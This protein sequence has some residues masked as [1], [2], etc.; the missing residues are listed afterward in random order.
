MSIEEEKKERVLEREMEGW[1]LSVMHS[2]TF[3]P[4]GTSSVKGIWSL[5]WLQRAPPS[6]AAVTHTVLPA[7]DL[8]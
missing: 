4:F 5:S 7:M 3:T 1:R 8:H 6:P 2:L